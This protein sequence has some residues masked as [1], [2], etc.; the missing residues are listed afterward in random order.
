MAHLREAAVQ[1]GGWD[2]LA[3]ERLRHLVGAH[4]QDAQQQGVRVGNHEEVQRWIGCALACAVK[5]A[6]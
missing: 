5:P 4:L 3:I 2:A 6:V 1:G